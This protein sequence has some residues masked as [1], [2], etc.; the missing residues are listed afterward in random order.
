M[1]QSPSSKLGVPHDVVVVESKAPPGLS[2]PPHSGRY[3]MRSVRP[4]SSSLRPSGS[5]FPS[6]DAAA[7]LPARRRRVV[8]MAVVGA[9]ALAAGA[10]VLSKHPQA[11]GLTTEV[12]S[13]RAG[14]RTTPNGSSELWA[15][16]SGPAFVIDPSIAR[17]DTSGGD[18]KGAIVEAFSTWDSAGLG[19]PKA[20]F[21]ISS[22]AGTAA[23][24]GVSRILYAP[25]TVPG[26]EDALA[27]TIAYADANT[28]A[29]EEAD[30]IFNS[31]YTFHVFQPAAAAKTTDD[32]SICSGDYD[33][34]NVATHET[35]HVYGLGEDTQDT[36]T[37][38]YLRSSPCET[39]K[40]SLSA[41]DQQVMA[42]LYAPS[43][44][45]AADTP[46]AASGSPSGGCGGATVASK[47]PGSG[48]SA[49]IV[50]ALAVL[51]SLR[52]R[53]ARHSA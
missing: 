17:M 10:G 2:M 35:G 18:A 44:A 22:T 53:R 21:T 36:T 3:S 41:P 49:W 4:L 1:Q 47:R 43:V 12:V 39:H 50:S 8:G 5:L 51:V 26:M 34:Q 14:L 32:D 30:V 24:D 29:I 13:G 9:I 25:I 6:E 11:G 20:S 38:M 7:A 19:L 40:R 16:N 37:T 46:A 23:Q 48:G 27:L 45:A 42:A 33:V 31:K 15:A 28:G 52:R